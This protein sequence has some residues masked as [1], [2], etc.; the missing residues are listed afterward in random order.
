MLTPR[1]GSGGEMLYAER[2]YLF[3]PEDCAVHDVLIHEYLHALHAR[4]I[5]VN[6][7]WLTIDREEFVRTFQG[8]PTLCPE[9]N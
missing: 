2:V 3:L 9:E 5:H 6:S 8:E 7:I 1:L 4:L